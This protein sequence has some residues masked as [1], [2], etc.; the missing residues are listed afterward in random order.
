MKKL[1]LSILTFVYMA[2]SSGIAMEIHYCMGKEAG[3]DYYALEDNKKCG[4]CGMKEKKGGCC[5]D[6]HK[7]VK[8]EDSHKQASND[9]SFYAGDIAVMQETP[10]FSWNVPASPAASSV[11][12]NSPPFDHGPSACVM[13]CVFRL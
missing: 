7:F 1:L 13:N 3:V 12:I 5:Q 6:E 8:L 11:N 2:V 9:I 4:R 10:V